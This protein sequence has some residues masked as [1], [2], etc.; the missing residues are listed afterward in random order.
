MTLK[1]LMDQLGFPSGTGDLDES[2]KWAL[3]ELH[4]RRA[5]ERAFVPVDDPVSLF[6]DMFAPERIAINHVDTS[7][8]IDFNASF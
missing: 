6:L 2:L 1:E 8:E 3:V 7:G 5:Q 4:L